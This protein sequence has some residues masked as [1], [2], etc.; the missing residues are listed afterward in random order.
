MAGVS[1]IDKLPEIER[2]RVVK[3]LTEAG[4]SPDFRGLISKL[5]LKCSHHALW[6]YHRDKIKPAIQR[7]TAALVA[8]LNDT[9]VH[10]DKGDSI[11][12]RIAIREQAQ[13]ETRQAL[14]DDPIKSLWIAQQERLHQA[15]KDTHENKAYDTYAKLESVA[16]K[17]YE[18]H[19]K[20]IQHPGF[21]SAAPAQAGAT[22]VVVIMPTAAEMQARRSRVID[23]VG[24]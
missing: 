12:Q 7:S 19:A 13:C 6:R 24:E 16:A 5:Q 22:T 8:T 23:V 11:D 17:N 1:S 14:A 9:N 3:A 4:E 20:T 15:I 18:G 21:T 2:L 10:L